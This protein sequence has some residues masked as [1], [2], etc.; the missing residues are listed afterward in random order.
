MRTHEFQHENSYLAICQEHLGQIPSRFGR[1]VWIS[2]HADPHSGRYHHPEGE[3]QFGPEQINET[4][5]VLHSMIFDDWLDSKIKDQYHDMRRFLLAGNPQPESSAIVKTWMHS[6]ATERLLPAAILPADRKL[7]SFS[8]AV[9]LSLLN[10][11]MQTNM[12]TVR[13]SG[14]ATTIIELLDGEAAPWK[15]TLESVARE[16]NLSGDYTRH[17]FKTATGA[18]VRQF[19]RHLR[20][21]SAAH[22]LRT[23]RLSIEEIAN[24]LGY[25]YTTNFPRDCRAYFELSPARYRIARGRMTHA[26]G[27]NQLQRTDIDRK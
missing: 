10:A 13:T 5:A 24:R 22:L 9:I 26:L 17:L 23:T 12:D 14:R 7:Y 19:Q 15:W 2:Q 3:R 8:I 20:M 21:N 18:T 4:L 27:T 6:G 16:L 1:L 25:E 11:Q